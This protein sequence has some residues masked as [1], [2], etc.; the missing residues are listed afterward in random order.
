MSE[1]VWQIFN[2]G[3]IS[4]K[5][6]TERTAFLEWGSTPPSPLKSSAPLFNAMPAP[7]L[8]KNHLPYSVNPKSADEDTPCKYIY[9]ARNPKD[10]VVSYYKFFQA[11]ITGFNGPFEFFAKLFVEGKGKCCQTYQLAFHSFTVRNRS[12]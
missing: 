2:D 1:I 9:M 6:I 10:V 7:R 4:N 11:P 12:N 8:L 3:A 5:H